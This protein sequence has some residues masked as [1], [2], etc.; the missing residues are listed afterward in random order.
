MEKRCV[1]RQRAKLRVLQQM[2]KDVVPCCN[3]R[4]SHPSSRRRSTVRKLLYF[5]RGSIIK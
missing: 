5:T 4:M 2:T 3:K 1:P